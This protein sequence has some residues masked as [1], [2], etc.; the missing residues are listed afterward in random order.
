M[1]VKRPA[2][3]VALATLVWGLLQPGALAEQQAQD[4]TD[5]CTVTL[6][7]NYEGKAVDLTDHNYKTGWKTKKGGGGVTLEAPR[8]KPLYG[9]Y[10][11][12]DKLADHPLYEVKKQGVWQDLDVPDHQFL[13][14]YIDLDGVDGVKIRS[15]ANDIALCEVRTFGQGT[16]PESVQRWDPPCDRADLLLIPTHP[17]DEHL[18]F[19]GTMPVYA[20]EYKKKVQV[21]YMTNPS[22]LRRHEALD[23][24]WTVGV[25]QAP[26][27]SPFKDIY[28]KSLEEAETQY[29][30][31]DVVGWEVEM[32]RRFKPLVVID[33][34]VQGEYGHGVHR[35]NTY[36]LMKALPAAAD[37]TAYPESRDRYGTWDTPKCYLHMRDENNRLMDWDQPLSAFGGKTGYE[38]AAKGFLCHA[39]QQNGHHEMS[40]KGRRDCRSFGL[41]RSLVG[42]DTQM[43]DFLE[44]TPQS[45]FAPASTTAAETTT[46]L[47]T[48][49]AAS[50][51]PALDRATTAASETVPVPDRTTDPSSP[52]VVAIDASS[53]AS[54]SPKD[55]EQADSSS[56]LLTLLALALAAALTVSV[57]AL[58]RSLKKARRSSHR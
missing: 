17:D 47:Q 27:F 23:G 54:T 57:L 20:G 30:V 44:H 11:M 4:L 13:H 40:K 6:S 12:W 46:A 38:M 43:N 39:S 25:R 10:L 9:L 42:E 31:Q 35:L 41:Y 1:K 7:G 24:L 37:D 36:C 2:M 55:S 48:T 32:L 15:S 8:D 29:K 52:A 18:F 34:D 49:T 3:I 21:V 28:C 51:T 50:S 22:R 33:H 14:Q 58:R 56:L 5:A 45:L 53:S 19:G 26:V 16:L